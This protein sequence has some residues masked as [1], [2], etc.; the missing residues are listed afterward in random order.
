MMT[1]PEIGLFGIFGYFAVAIHVG[2]QRN[3]SKLRQLPGA[4]LGII[5]QA[6]PFGDDDDARDRPV[7]DLRLL[8]R[9]HTC[10]PPAQCIQAP[11][12]AWRGPWH[13]R[14][15]PTIRG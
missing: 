2:R 5:V 11:P 1:M 14:S 15:S 13:N 7:W 4:A 6:P 9:R 8:C 10:R 3:V 12:I